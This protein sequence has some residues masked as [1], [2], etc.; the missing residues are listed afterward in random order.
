MDK[1]ITDAKD[2]TKDYAVMSRKKL[3]K[4]VGL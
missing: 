2:E 4:E 1:L 3:E